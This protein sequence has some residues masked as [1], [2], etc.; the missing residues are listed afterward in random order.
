MSDC[1]NIIPKLSSGNLT[2]ICRVYILWSYCSIVSLQWELT[3]FR[4]TFELCKLPQ[5]SLLL[6]L[7]AS[8]K[9][10]DYRGWDAL[11]GAVA[12]GSIDVISIL[13]DSGCD[14]SARDA[15]SK[16]KQCNRYMAVHQ[17]SSECVEIKVCSIECVS[18]FVRMTHL[19]TSI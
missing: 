4:S 12:E 17:W 10:T 15:V 2:T 16:Y 9:V 1:S 3:H 5:V 8:T 19:S 6:E 11:K 14:P 13:I 18:K 7:G